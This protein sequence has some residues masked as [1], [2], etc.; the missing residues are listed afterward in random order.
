MDSLKALVAQK[1]KAASELYEGKKY[2][3]RSELEAAEL[4]RLRE[5]EQ[6]EL[7]AKVRGQVC[8]IA[9]AVHNACVHRLHARSKPKRRRPSA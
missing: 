2:V 5:E 1:R 6:R 3:K 9:S 8:I 7:E 4:R